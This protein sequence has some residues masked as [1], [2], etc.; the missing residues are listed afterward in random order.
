MTKLI[1]TKH[2]AAT[3]FVF[4][5]FMIVCCVKSHA[6]TLSRLVESSVR[7]TTIHSGFH[8]IRGHRGHIQVQI[9]KIRVRL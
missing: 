8:I 3:F 2:A 9:E 1:C 6:F 5:P 7:L 4:A